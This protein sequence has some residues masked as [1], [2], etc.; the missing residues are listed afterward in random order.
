MSLINIAGIPTE[1][2]V[3]CKHRH[4]CLSLIFFNFWSYKN[5]NFKHIKNF[6][7]M[8][9]YLS[10]KEAGIHLI[11]NIGSLIRNFKLFIWV[12]VCLLV[13]MPNQLRRL[14]SYL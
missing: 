11:E 9:V 6:V 1:Y 7:A 8:K 10:R 2:S 4:I 3:M 13:L 12:S 5:H 14:F